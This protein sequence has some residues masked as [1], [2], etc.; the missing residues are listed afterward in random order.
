M[1]LEKSPNQEMQKELST[2]LLL[3]WK[4]VLY[5]QKILSIYGNT[6][7]EIEILSRLW[8]ERDSPDIHFNHVE[9]TTQLEF[10]FIVFRKVI[11]LYVE[12]H[13]EYNKIHVNIHP[14][15]LIDENFENRLEWIF[16]AYNFNDFE[17]L[18]FEILEEWRMDNIY[19]LNK[20]INFLRK[21][22][23]EVWLDD[24]PNHNNADLLPL[25][26]NLDFVK[27]DKSF[28]LSLNDINKDTV[29]DV[30]QQ[31]VTDIE[32]FHPNVK[33]IIEWIE[34]LRCYNYIMNN[35]Y[36]IDSVQWYLFGQPNE[37]GA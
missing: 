22:R 11:A 12:W 14:F 32:K 6:E 2:E 29:R 10:D 13:L 24:F 15:T 7:E 21:K 26:D 28:I 19:S 34:D 25:I 33:I 4:V 20:N 17:K 30:I 37:I 35:I 1:K 9:E 27:I 8:D 16:K 31:L 18:S 23:I 3:N 5:K 36:W